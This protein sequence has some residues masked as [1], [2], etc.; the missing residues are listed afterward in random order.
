M[1]ILFDLIA[2]M[3]LAMTLSREYER[4]TQGEMLSV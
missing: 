1:L 2:E 3:G 4:K